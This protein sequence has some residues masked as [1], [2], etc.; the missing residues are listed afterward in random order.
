MSSAQ[1]VRRILSGIMMI[2]GAVLIISMK[3]EG[4]LLVMTFLS[5][6]FIVLGI[7]TLYY[8]STMAKHMVGGKEI[9][10][11]GI[12]ILDFGWLTWTLTS[13]PKYY[14]MLYLFGIHLFS[15]I[16]D[17]LRTVEAK[18][19]AGNT[20]RLNLLQGV[21]NVVIALVCIVFLDSADMVVYI[22][23]A[24]LIYSGINRI[25]QS[26]RKTAIVFIP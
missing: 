8:Y 13:V 10:Y 26:F 5:I 19:Y 9:L 25:V 14:I 22:Y 7:R 21:V 4:Y 23:G 20:W 24:G 18:H 3:E 6:S 11:Q 17:I 12:I 1:R 16:V 15:G 2:L